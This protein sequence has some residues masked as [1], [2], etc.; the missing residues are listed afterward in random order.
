MSD[1]EDW[2]PEG[3]GVSVASD[4]PDQFVLIG[5]RIKIGDAN[6]TVSGR[7][8]YTIF[9]TL[10]DVA[11]GGRV[12][13]NGVGAGWDVPITRAVVMVTGPFEWSGLRCDRGATGAAVAGAGSAIATGAGSGAGAS[14]TGGSTGT[15]SPAIRAVSAARGPEALTTVPA[16]TTAPDFSVTEVTHAA[17]RPMATTSSVT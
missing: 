17:A 6:Q 15:S 3:S 10:D 7:H 12:A 14:T 5:D 13:F 1:T 2:T 16:R 11:P 9:Y 8:R 4:A